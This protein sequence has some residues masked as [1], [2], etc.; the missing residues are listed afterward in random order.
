MRIFL[1]VLLSSFL[2]IADG[3]SSLRMMARELPTSRD[4]QRLP[5]GAFLGFRNTK[6]VPGFHRAMSLDPLMPEGGL[7]P[8]VIRVLGVGGGGCNAVSC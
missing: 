1:L 2:P 6:D 8:C 5:R 3:L 4:P 7:S